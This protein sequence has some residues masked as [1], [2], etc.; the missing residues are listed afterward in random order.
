MFPPYISTIKT[1]MTTPMLQPPPWKTPSSSQQTAAQFS[2]SSLR[3]GSELLGTSSSSGFTGGF[4]SFPSLSPTPS[5]SSSSVTTAAMMMTTTSSE[6]GKTEP[7]SPQFPLTTSYIAALQKRS[8]TN[9]NR[10]LGGTSEGDYNN[11]LEE[12]GTTGEASSTAEQSGEQTSSGKNIT[13]NKEE[14]ID[15][16]FFKIF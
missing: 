4:S 8:T 16:K 15:V 13:E 7:L 11:S 3:L 5:G 12:E 6:F 2:S 1:T 10:S 9:N 14:T